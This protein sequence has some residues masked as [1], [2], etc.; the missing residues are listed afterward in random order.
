MTFRRS[1]DRLDILMV[2]DDDF[3]TNALCQTLLENG[4]D[5]RMERCVDGTEALEYLQREHGLLSGKFIILL[6]LS[7]PQVNGYDFLTT[8]R[9]DPKLRRSVIFVLST[10]SEKKDINA[11]YD[12]NV[13]GY[14]LRTESGV[15][16]LQIFRFLDAYRSLVTLSDLMLR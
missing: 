11:A 12:L 7:S 5:C 13:A 10:S 16:N 4:I 9:S 2:V 15:E 8:I 3:D 14:I 1:S 6:D